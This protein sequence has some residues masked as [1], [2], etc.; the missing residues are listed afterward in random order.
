MKL[1]LHR[2]KGNMSAIFGFGYWLKYP[3]KITGISIIIR[4]KEFAVGNSSTYKRLADLLS[5]RQELLDV[6]PTKL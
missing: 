6:L 2:V 5:V 1:R 3:C 4:K